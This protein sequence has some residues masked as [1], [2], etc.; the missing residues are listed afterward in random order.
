[1]I[2]S[3][4]LAP[5]RTKVSTGGSVFSSGFSHLLPEA[6]IYSPFLQE[7]T[8]GS[9]YSSMYSH[10]QGIAPVLEMAML[11]KLFMILVD[12]PM[13]W[14]VPQKRPYKLHHGKAAVYSA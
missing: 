1:M 3:V 10:R 4:E 14:D 7:F 13:M 2:G 5:V 6:P 8:R 12:T 11:S 9:G